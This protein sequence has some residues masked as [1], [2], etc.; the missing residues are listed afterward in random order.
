M[1]EGNKKE[2]SM[3]MIL[4]MEEKK[5]ANQINETERSPKFV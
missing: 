1:K 4:L 5:K 3:K 2:D